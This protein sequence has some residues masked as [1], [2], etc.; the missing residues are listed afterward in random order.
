M[1]LTRYCTDC[2]NARGLMIY[3]APPQA[4]CAVCG[5][6]QLEP[7]PE[8]ASGDDLPN[9]KQIMDDPGAA[10]WL[11]RALMAALKRDPVDAANDAEVLARVLDRRCRQILH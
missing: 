2:L 4:G 6:S 10:M 8:A 7:F 5:G 9:E 11:K 1:N 3:Y